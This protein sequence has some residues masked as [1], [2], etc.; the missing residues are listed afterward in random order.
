MESGVKRRS[1]IRNSCVLVGYGANTPL[2]T[3]CLTEVICH[4]K[5]GINSGN[6]LFFRKSVF[7]EERYVLL[8]HPSDKF[9][10]CL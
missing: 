2:L 10:I 8:Q 1:F 5:A 9:S 6:E 3:G 4:T 7:K